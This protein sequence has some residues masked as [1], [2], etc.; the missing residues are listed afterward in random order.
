MRER[1]KRRERERRDGDR[2]FHPLLLSLLSFPHSARLLL[3]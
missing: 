3:P 1:E 2:D